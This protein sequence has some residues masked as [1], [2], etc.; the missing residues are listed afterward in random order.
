MDISHFFQVPTG[1][2]TAHDI[3]LSGAFP[4]DRA[5]RATDHTTVRASGGSPG[6]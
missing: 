1:L 4:A 3:E 2:A 5:C 6:W